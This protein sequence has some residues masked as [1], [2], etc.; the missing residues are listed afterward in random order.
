MAHWPITLSDAIL[1]VL[2]DAPD[3]TAS[4]ADIAAAINARR[5]SV[6]PSSMRRRSP[7]R[8]R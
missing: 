3:R 4:T 6:S 1:I 8:M 5:L 7:Q 2:Q